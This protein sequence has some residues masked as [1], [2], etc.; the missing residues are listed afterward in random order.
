MEHP[1]NSSS[2]EGFIHQESCISSSLIR[3][4][5]RLC[6]A[7]I[8]KQTCRATDKRQGMPH[9]HHRS[10]RRSLER[11]KQ[12][13]PRGKQESYRVGDSRR[14]QTNTYKFLARVIEP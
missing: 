9:R 10:K 7:S 8:A 13:G 4:E 12:V 1:H 3:S 5:K 6:N 2:Y 14:S 11:A